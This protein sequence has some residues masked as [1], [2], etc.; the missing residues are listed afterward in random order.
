MKTRGKVWFKTV[1]LV[2]VLFFLGAILAISPLTSQ[3]RPVAAA[4]LRNLWQNDEQ[5][6]LTTDPDAGGFILYNDHGETRCRAAR[7]ESE[8]QLLKPAAGRALQ[9]IYDSRSEGLAPQAGMKIILR[10]TAQLNNF[11][12]AKA[13][14]IRAAQRW[15]SLILNPITVVIDVDFGP[16]RFGEPYGEGTLGS[17]SGQALGGNA[18]YSG[19]RNRLIPGAA[20]AAEAAL[21]NALPPGELPT[22]LGGTTGVT[23]P[24]ILLRALGAIAPV[25]DPDGEK[26]NYGDPPSIGFNSAFPFDFDPSNGIAPD[27]T[28]F[29]ATAVHEIG[30]ALG[31][32][33]SAGMKELAPQAAVRATILDFF[34][35]RPGVTSNT[36]TTTP[37]ILSSGGS[38]SLFNGAQT[39]ALSTGRPDHT[40]GDERQAS[41]WKD[42]SLTGQYL[43]IMDPTLPGGRRQEITANDLL[44]FHLIGYQLNTNPSQSQ[45]EELKTDDGT[46]ENGAL[47][48]GLI[49]VNRLTPSAYPSTLQKIRIY[50]APAQSQPDPSGAQIRLLAFNAANLGNTPPS[51]VTLL[52]NQTAT[53]PNVQNEGFFDY[54]ITNGPTINSGDWYIGF[55]APNPV[56]GVVFWGDTNGQQQQRGFYSTDNGQTYIGPLVL[57]GTPPPPANMLI[58][59]VVQNGGGTTQCN[60]SITPTSQQFN[61]SGGSGSVN[62]AA[63]SGCNWTA[64]SN[65]NFIAVTSGASGSGNGTVNFNVAANTSANQRTGTLVIAGQTFTVTQASTTPTPTPTPGTGSADWDDRFSFPGVTS[66]NF[67]AAAVSGNNLYVGGLLGGIAGLDS[68]V[69]QNVAWW[70]GRR[71]RS[72]G[73]ADR[74]VYGLATNGN[75]VY[76]VGDFT[77]IGGVAARGVARWDGAK[78][79]IVGNGIGP[80]GTVQAVAVVNGE[81]Y[82]GGRF[83]QVDGQS[84]LNLAKWNGSSWS[85]V[86]NGTD[87]YVYALTAA[88]SDLYVGG[89]FARAGSVTANGIARWNGS[90]WS[91]LGSGTRGCSTCSSPGTVYSIAVNGSEVYIGGEF[92]LIGDLLVNSIARWNGS[93]W[94]VLGTGA[95]GSFGAGRVTRLIYVGNALYVTGDWQSIGGLAGRRIAKWDGSWSQLPGEHSTFAGYGTLAANGRGGLYFCGANTLGELAPNAVAEWTGNAW[96]ALGKGI[97]SGIFSAAVYAVAV[98]PNGDVYVGGN[99]IHANGKVV[100]SIARWDGDEWHALGRGLPPSPGSSSPGTAAAIAIIGNSV[101]VGGNFTQAG[102][103]GASNIARWESTT[104]TWSALGQGVNRSVTSLATSGNILYVGGTFTTAG[105]TDAKQLARWDGANWAKLGAKSPNFDPGSGSYKVLALLA[106][107][108]A[109]YIGGDF[110]TLALNGANNTVNGLVKWDSTTDQYSSFGAGTNIGVTINGAARGNVTALARG[111]DGIY[112]GGDFDQIAGVVAKALARFDDNGFSA[113]GANLVASFLRPTVL[114][115]TALGDDLYVGGGFIKAGTAT[116]NGIAKWST[117]GNAWSALGQGVL[118]S[119]LTTP[120]TVL[121][122][123]AGDGKIYVGGQF[124]VASDKPSA[125]FA[126][127]NTS[128]GNAQQNPVPILTSLNPNSATAGGQGFTLTV[129]GT[130]FVSGAT[131]RWNGQNR[132]TNFVSATQLTA[133]ITAADIANAGTASVTVFNPA[134]GGGVSNAV[135]FTITPSNTGTTVALTPGVAQTGTSAAPQ[136]PSQAVFH[137]TQ[138]TIQV[139][140]G[141]TQL[142]LD[143]SG[144]QDVDLFVRYGNPV[145]LQNNRL[146]ADEQSEQAT[147]EEQISVTALSAPALRP[148]LYYVALINYGPGAA[149]F[150]LTATLVTAADEVEREPN[151]SSASANPLPLAGQRTGN[152]ASNDR[153]EINFTYDD[154]TRDPIEDLYRFELTRE[155]L[156]DLLL[157]TPSTTADLDLFLFREENGQLTAVDFSVNDISLAGLSFERVTAGLK[158]GRYLVGV[159]AYKGAASYTLTARIINT[160]MI[161]AASYGRDSGL[162]PESIAS[163]FGPNLATSTAVATSLPL[164]TAL[165]GTTVTVRD[166]AGV[167]RL[168][169]LFF[170]A[171]TQINLQIPAGS[172][173]GLAVLKITNANGQSYTDVLN[174]TNAAPGLFTANSSG[175]GVPAGLVVRVRGDGSQSFE[176]IARFDQASNSLVPAPIDLGPATDTVVLVL[177]G[178]GARARSAL[179]RVQANFGKLNVAVSYAGAQGDLVGL[180][181]FNLV[182]PRSLAGSGEVELQLIVDGRSA[183]PVKLNIK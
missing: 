50:H 162:A 21:Y 152:V 124:I 37:R 98:A 8:L 128:G 141:T 92:P 90:S 22:D 35:F 132:T 41:H 43:G 167:E 151:E 127:W 19:L 93:S 148:G 11:P 137:P 75:D 51:N 99:F 74:T 48:A 72:M 10:S 138:Y 91:A 17:T 78:W 67:Y 175:A 130:N 7:T 171:Q 156:V 123:A 169:P 131:V 107:G 134:P 85:A 166:S 23:A 94:S 61:A 20:N 49:V 165:A 101:Y 46:L 110:G 111:R 147:S 30:H 14:F 38:Q 170:V 9:V 76:A 159:S 143:L 116:T 82:I 4:S 31:F 153:A 108:N 129:N 181:Q 139:P 178:T 115:L 33:S 117:T 16:Q 160:V 135:N 27:K 149:N 136:P 88:G 36:F 157:N 163:V 164:P 174:V 182:L 154:G 39:L 106:D 105:S 45:T 62:V 145:A 173:P 83:N 44:A 133:Q 119:D 125:A 104:N 57:S 86:G 172:A 80:D 97:H 168:A 183:N 25:A 112:I 56:N 81:L 176:N 103:T 52:L 155:T 66:H 63:G 144:N 69:S 114:A 70:D 32:T 158:P 89:N 3:L 140:A 54:T 68:Q 161:S 58:R 180:D 95:L 29:D 73:V 40:G 2:W 179:E 109:L 34:R 84:A 142:K 120:S 150:T 96:R 13:A 59:A 77:T 102:E 42:D 79:N 121:G 146:L 55:Q 47:V 24:S 5:E 53:I 60:Y 113:V 87:G 18:L 64:V 1:T 100:N 12:E 15:E 26:E 28:D 126:I 177:F 118:R 65:A 122:L 71:W 6:K